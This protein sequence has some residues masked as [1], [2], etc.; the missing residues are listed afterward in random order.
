MP[1]SDPPGVTPRDLELFRILAA[2]R[3]VESE[4]RGP[5]M[6]RSL[7]DGTRIRIAP[8]TSGQPLQ[9]GQVVA[10]LGGSRVI[11]HRIAWSAGPEQGDHLI[12]QGDGNWL[13]DPPIEARAVLGVVDECWKEG[14]WGA[15]PQA[16]RGLGPRLAWSASAALLR[17]LLAFSPAL[18]ARVARAMS[19]ARMSLRA[20]WPG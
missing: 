4:V 9:R 15:V 11:V 18:A 16:T 13:C 5:S 2:R 3:P 12:T 17:L 19:Y 6:G 10:F 8:P 20:L 7:P 14:A 1:V